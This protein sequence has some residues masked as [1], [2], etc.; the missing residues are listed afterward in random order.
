M[1]RL[2]VLFLVLCIALNLAACAIEIPISTED[3]GTT[4]ESQE[5]TDTIQTEAT[6]TEEITLEQFLDAVMG[7]WIFEDTIWYFD[8]GGPCFE[9]LMIWE[10]QCTTAVYPGGV[11]RPGLYDSFTQIDENTYQVVLLYEQ[12]PEES[13]WGYMPEDYGTITFVLTGN[14]TMEMKYGDGSYLTLIYGGQ[15]FEEASAS[16]IKT[17]G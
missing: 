1:K 12:T 11:D 16:A 17:R 3:S 13:Y 14:G 6:E 10:D 5:T 7:I 9:V 2:T 15:T 4:T 8:D